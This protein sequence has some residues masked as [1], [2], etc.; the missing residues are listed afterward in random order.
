MS[1]TAIISLII[2]T[3][4][5]LIAVFTSAIVLS[6]KLGGNAQRIEALEVA[7]KNEREEMQKKIDM[8]FQKLEVLA[9]V[10]PHRCDQM[11]R[12]AII[13]S[14]QE[15]VIAKMDSQDRRMDRIQAEIVSVTATVL[16][17]QHE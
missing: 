17:E 4:S 14:R 12:I 1:D 3:T 5:I 6:F 11:E 15:A 13:N 7:T 9:S 2:G 10:V 16:K 8:I